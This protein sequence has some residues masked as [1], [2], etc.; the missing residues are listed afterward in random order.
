MSDAEQRWAA[1]L[2]E[3]AIPPEILARAP[4]SPWGFPP[5]LF[6]H[7]DAEP[8]TPSHRRAA[9]ALPSGGTLLDV[10][11]GAGAS[12]LPLA[13]RA[14]CIVG[15][16]SSADMLR[17]FARAADERGV[18]HREVRGAWPGVAA[19]AGIADVVVCHHVFYNTPELGPFAEALTRAARRRVVVEMTATH[20]AAALNPLWHHFHGLARPQGPVW[21]DALAVLR[22]LG[23]E[24]EVER[25][26]RPPRRH[27]APRAE[28]VAFVRRRLCL[29]SAHDAEIDAVLGEEPVWSPQ[30]IVTMWWAGTVADRAE[31]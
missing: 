4:E 27:R 22:T 23:L 2:A 12:S 6:D 26:S 16:D 7:S 13:G 17:S 15:V 10:G 24:P 3:W 21:E 9:E 8:Y 19:D 30:D 31:A 14:G 20:P 25:W 29:T 5:A 18:D 11:V 28:L 1:A